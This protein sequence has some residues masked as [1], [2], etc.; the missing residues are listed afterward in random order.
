MEG[1][2]D[3]ENC[4]YDSLNVD[5]QGSSVKDQGVLE[6]NSERPSF[7]YKFV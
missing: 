7:I 2:A 6:W 5:W 4:I 1:T 3:A